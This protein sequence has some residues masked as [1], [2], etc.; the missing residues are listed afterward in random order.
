MFWSDPHDQH[1]RIG[2]VL[3]ETF[4]KW[5][6]YRGGSIVGICCCLARSSQIIQLIQ[7]DDEVQKSPPRFGHRFDAY[8]LRLP[9]WDWSLPPNLKYA[10]TV[11]GCVSHRLIRRWEAWTS[12]TII[13]QPNQTIILFIH[14]PIEWVWI[15]NQLHQAVGTKGHRSFNVHPRKRGMRTQEL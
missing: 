15:I 14:I 5:F 9:K 2:W 11:M 7:V 1:P 8:E 3:C 13:H 10:S 4:Q 6:I 12:S